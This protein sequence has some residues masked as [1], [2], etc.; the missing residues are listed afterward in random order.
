MSKRINRDIRRWVCFWL[1]LG[2][3]ASPG[4]AW[5]QKAV[6]TAAT[7]AAHPADDYKH[8]MA[9]FKAGQ[10]DEAVYVFYRGQL[11]YRIYL[12]AHPNLKPDGD[13]ALF[14]SLNEIVGRP[15]NEYAFGDIP[16]LA[17]TIDRVLAWEAANDDPYTPKAQYAA[18]HAEVSAGLQSLRN[19]IVQ[20]REQIRAQRR[21]ANLPNRN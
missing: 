18:A 9:L 20:Q 11:R 1:A 16:A 7:A 19:Q 12:R 4:S 10:R 21:A 13:P 8:A 5:A 15:I 14:A 6:G 2:L 17:E 3:L